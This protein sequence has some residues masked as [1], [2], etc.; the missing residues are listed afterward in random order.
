MRT[1]W[2]SGWPSPPATTGEGAAL[3]SAVRVTVAVTVTVRVRL[4][5]L[6]T[7]TATSWVTVTV[8]G[9]GVEAVWAGDD[10][11]HAP[12]S[13]NAPT[14]NAVAAVLMSVRN[15]KPPSTT[16]SFASLIDSLIHF[17]S[18]RGLPADSLHRCG[19]RRW[20][21]SE[22]PQQR[23]STPRVCLAIGPT[24]SRCV[25]INKRLSAVGGSGCSS[26]RRDRVGARPWLARHWLRQENEP[27][28]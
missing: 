2:P 1:S 14:H 5:V 26:R 15:S 18:R 9:V 13:G 20:C 24:P 23:R 6:V 12:S 27:R 25:V 17:L 21:W 11:E 28:T 19:P 16:E 10:C 7:G 8:D 3:G 4:T 22:S